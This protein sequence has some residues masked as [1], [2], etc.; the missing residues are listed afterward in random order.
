MKCPHCEAT[1]IKVV[2]TKH[3]DDLSIDRYRTCLICKQSWHTKELQIIKEPC[4][5]VLLKDSRG[6][7]IS[8]KQNP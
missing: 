5:V 2:S 7:F 1:R 8:P 6:R 3:L 4:E